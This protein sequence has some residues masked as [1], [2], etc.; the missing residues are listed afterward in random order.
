MFDHQMLIA[1]DTVQ[2]YVYAAPTTIGWDG[3]HHF[4]DLAADDPDADY[5]RLYF[6]YACFAARPLG[7]KGKVSAGPFWSPHPPN[8]LGHLIG[9]EVPGNRDLTFFA[10]TAPLQFDVSAKCEVLTL[11]GQPELLELW[12]N[13]S[14][15][16]PLSQRENLDVHA[17]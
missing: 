14:I 6:A 17:N 11:C 13:N 7:W 16:G 3:W 12:C 10:A 5:F 2:L 9:W 4:R 15:A 8:N 1:R